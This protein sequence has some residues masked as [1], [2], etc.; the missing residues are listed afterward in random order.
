M[1]SGSQTWLVPTATWQRPV[2]S[3]PFQNGVKR[4]EFSPDNTLL[5]VA[6]CGDNSPV[7]DLSFFDAEKGRFAGRLP[8]GWRVDRTFDFHFV[9]GGNSLVA[10]HVNGVRQWDLAVLRKAWLADPNSPVATGREVIPWES[11][12]YPSRLQLTR[13]GD[14]RR[15]GLLDRPSQ[16]VSFGR[17]FVFD[18]PATGQLDVK[19]LLPFTVAKQ[20]ISPE[21]YWMTLSSDGSRVAIQRAE[22]L[23]IYDVGSRALEHQFKSGF[24]Q[25]VFDFAP[26]GRTF[27]HLDP[28]DGRQIV[29]RGCESG[30]VTMALPLSGP[31]GIP[32]NAEDVAYS[33]QSDF[34]VAA[35]A[36]GGRAW[37]GFNVW[38]LATG[39]LVATVPTTRGSIQDLVF[40]PDGKRLATVNADNSIT[41]WDFAEITR[42]SSAR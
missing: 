13:S 17:P 31:Q 25:I 32:V 24:S 26:D 19:K 7:G 4:A 2:S 37:T 15:W 42:Q 22:A 11:A 9:P 12:A 20:Q 21:S 14:G 3:A 30:E 27:A 28:A 10:A 40:R 29:L 38:S 39:K 35:V 23:E 6:T 18:L 34:V 1:A 36:A 33:P 41:L 16:Q 5:G 8:L